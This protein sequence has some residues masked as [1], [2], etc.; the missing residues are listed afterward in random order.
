MGIPRDT[1]EALTHHAIVG[2]GKTYDRYDMQAEKRQAVDAIA[3]Y[4]AETLRRRD[5]AAQ[6][7]A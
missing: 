6:K 3:G 2:S 1:T 7:A 5:A 4:I